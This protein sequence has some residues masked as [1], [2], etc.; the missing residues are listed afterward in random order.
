M[1]HRNLTSGRD[2]EGE[3]IERIHR[4]RRLDLGGLG[5]IVISTTIDIPFHLVVIRNPGEGL[6][7]YFQLRC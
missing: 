4:R 2:L 1:K 6:H 7:V 3:L 5:I